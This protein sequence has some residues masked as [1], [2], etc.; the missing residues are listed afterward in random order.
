MKVEGNKP[1]EQALPNHW[2][3][4]RL[5]DV[6][7]INPRFDKAS[8]DD[9][10][11]ISF[12]SMPAVEA[13]SG[14]ID[15]SEIRRFEKVKK[16]F[17]GF[18]EK[19]VLFAKITPCMENG[20]MVV[21][22]KLRNGVG[23]GSTEFHVIRG[24]KKLLPEYIYYFVSSK[25]FRVDA[26]HNMTGAVG[27]KRV[28]KKYLEDSVIPVPPL[29]EQKDIIAKIETLFSELDN[30]IE[31]LK[32][33][34]QQL[35]AYRQAVLKHAFEGK[36]T[37]QWRQQNPDKLESPE[38][39]LARIQQ[40]REQRYQQQLEEW[41]QAVKAWE[42]NGKEGKRPRKP[43]VPIKSQGV[44]SD[45]KKELPALPSG[46][47][48]IRPEEIS[49]AED[50]AIG[51]GPF[52]SNL[53]VSDYRDAGVP[54]IFVRNITRKDFVS[55]LKYIERKKFFDLYAHSVKPLDL[56]ITKMGDPPGDCEIYPDHSPVAVL[57]ADCLKFR[58]FEGAAERRFYM[59][60]IKSNFVKRQL[61]LITKGVAQKKISVERFKTVTLPMPSYQEQVEIADQIEKIFSL[62]EDQE[63]AIS[64]SLEGAGILR[65]SILGKA[66]SGQ[67]V[68]GYDIKT[69]VGKTTK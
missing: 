9:E 12:V 32:T 64:S 41:K 53:K 43:R 38:Q 21:V 59:Y 62:I 30:G 36:L 17:T 44:T 15:V 42:D 39:L 7:E 55:D 20:K 54:L 8:L 24:G 63:K 51:I 10:T 28:P 56:V 18:L 45:E 29:N 60:C 40:E 48:W 23:F 14:K 61:G 5:V 19:D 1:K 6:S 26:E 35:K 68:D 37:E 49:A 25:R 66:F 11:E 69:Y 65:Q 58:L 3:A 46:W 13:E 57:T 47:A 16:G 67:L 34:R 2:T 4:Q 22:P 27:Q 52:G 33:A 31:F 50:H